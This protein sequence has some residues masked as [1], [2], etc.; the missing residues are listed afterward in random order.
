MTD[1]HR[2]N[3]YSLIQLLLLTLLTMSALSSL[4][5][6]KVEAWTMHMFGLPYDADFGYGEQWRVVLTSTFFSLL[7]LIGPILLL[8]RLVKNTRSSYRRM[9]QLQFKTETLAKYDSLSGLINRRVFM[10][11]LRDR[12]TQGN[13]IVV[14]LIDLDRFKTINDQHGHSAGDRVLVEVARRL[15]EIALKHEGTAARLGGDEFCL[16]LMAY[17]EKDELRQIAQAIVSCLSAPMIDTPESTH[18]GATVGIARSWS[19]TQNA[20]TL[21][22]YAD[23]AMYRGKNNGRSTYNFHDTE[24]ES[25]LRAQLDQDFALKRAVE[26]EE[27]I[28]FFQPIVALPE[29]N[30]VGFEILAR[31]MKPDKSMGMPIDFIPVLERL[32]LIPAMTRSLVKQACTAARNWDDHLH[33]S[34]NVSAA[35]ITD[36]FF[37]DRLLEQLKHENFPF[38]RFEVEITEEAL[39]GNLEAAQRNLSKL[40]GHGITVALDDFGTGYSGLYHLTRLSIDKIKIDRSFFEAGQIDHLPMVEAILGMA[41]SLKMKVTAEGIE[42]FHLPY[43]PS[44]LANN[45]CHFAQ[46]YLYG[47]PQAGVDTASRLHSLIRRHV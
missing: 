28:P 46:G 16:L 23:T 5:E 11:L 4:W 33:L 22:H 10:D 43:L 41:R 8:K 20:S 7:S 27:I 40:H 37:P 19:D 36:E 29:Q 15:N 6:F 12:L 25:K 3:S 13:P 42:D 45:G 47:H 39:V 18:L 26:Q 34:L 35:M 32:G 21:L 9:Q 38:N 30:V 31:W 24:Y 1:F 44:W 2:S 17:K 14:M